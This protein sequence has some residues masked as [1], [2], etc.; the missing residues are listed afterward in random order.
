MNE[1]LIMTV[2]TRITSVRFIPNRLVCGA[3]TIKSAEA[4]SP[5]S[6]FGTGRHE[7]SALFC[8][9]YL[10]GSIQVQESRKRVWYFCLM[11]DF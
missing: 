2:T 9:T 7:A 5:V 6:R 10:I 1:E 3:P 4:S 11:H 8:L